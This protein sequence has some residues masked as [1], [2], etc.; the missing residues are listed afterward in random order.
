MGQKQRE[1]SRE[2]LEKVM[3]VADAKSV[4]PTGARLYLND[5]GVYCRMNRLPGGGRLYQAGGK[6]IAKLRFIVETNGSIVVRKYRPGGWECALEATYNYARLSRTYL[7]AKLK[8]LEAEQEFSNLPNGQCIENRV[9]LVEKLVNERPDWTWP[10]LGTVYSE[11]GRFKDAE[12][13]YIKGIEMWPNTSSP[14]DYLAE[15]Y[16]YALAN[17]GLLSPPDDFSHPEW[18]KVSLNDIGYTFVQVIRLAEKHVAEA[19]RLAPPKDS[20]LRGSLREKLSVLRR[21]PEALSTLGTDELELRQ[22][23]QM[24][25]NN[26]DEAVHRIEQIVSRNPDSAPGWEGLGLGYMKTGRARD[27]ERA[28]LKAI[29]LSPRDPGPHLN[30]S[31]LYKVVMGALRGVTAPPGVVTPPG[32]GD[33]F[34]DITLEALGCS[35]EYAR[36]MAEEHAHEVLKLTGDKEFRRAARNSL[37]EIRMLDNI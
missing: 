32:Y 25:E 19:L 35:Y 14:H 20:A 37:E 11:A 30:M 12:M 15:F 28:L 3:A 26:P 31:T 24:L 34:G 13:V 21:L 27:A 4:V 29:S 33:I 6:F 2:L 16:L 18:A 22:T 10:F 9:L 5:W 1:P 17:A 36:K 23:Q 7:E 8:L